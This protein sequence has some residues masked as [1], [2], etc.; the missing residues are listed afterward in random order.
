MG[1]PLVYA[2]QAYSISKRRN[3]AGFSKDV[4]AVLLIANIARCFWWLTERYELALLLQ[5]VLM[6]V[7][8]LGMLSLV[9]RYQ[10]DRL[11]SSSYTASYEDYLYP[12]RQQLQR[13]RPPPQSQNR[14]QTSTPSAA[15]QTLPSSVPKPSPPPASSD[16]GI[17]SLFSAPSFGGS[18]GKYIPLLSDISLPPLPLLDR[19]DTNGTDFELPD[20]GEDHAMLE[21]EEDLNPVSLPTRIFRRVKRTTMAFGKQAVVLLGVRNDGS[22]RRDGSDSSRPLGFWTWMSMPR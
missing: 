18:R 14:F 21:D 1:A 6:I 22:R 2:D 3:S 9:L 10:E 15:D 16:A 4:C 7:S 5:S 20:E 8:Q 12:E 17:R 11:T 19:R 13:P